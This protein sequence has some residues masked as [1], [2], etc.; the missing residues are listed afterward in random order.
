MLDAITDVG[1]ITIGHA[2]DESALTGCTVILAGPGATVGADVRGLAPGTRETDLCRPG[3]LVEDAQ[4][5]LLAGGSAFGLDAAGGVMRYLH[6]AGLGFPTGAVSVPVVPAAV[7][8][9]L[10]L[11]SV[12]WPDAAMGYTACLT[13]SGGPVAQGNV[14]AGTG[15]TVGK[16][17]GPNGAMKG[18]IGTASVQAGGVVVGAIV[19]V[20]ALGNVVDPD[21]GR[22]LAGARSSETGAIVHTDDF[23]LGG[24]AVGNTTIGVVATDARLSPD[25]VH[26]IAAAAHDGLARTIRPVHTLY[27]GDALFALATGAAGRVEI[28]PVVLHTAAV[29]A[30]ERAVVNAVLHARAAGGLPAAAD[31]A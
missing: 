18:G 12:A 5:V 22:A 19:A 8:F 10:G 3:T 7:L 4:A 14:G 27:D 1:G 25:E 2:Q 26:R 15:A 13:A 28:N 17:L 21:T 30:V 23:L 24:P 20:N 29:R 31:L 16:M 9:D 6:E 11:G